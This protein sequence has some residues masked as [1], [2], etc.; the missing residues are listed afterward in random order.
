MSKKEV[1]VCLSKS[2]NV[3]SDILN[4]LTKELAFSFSTFIDLK[5]VCFILLTHYE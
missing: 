3:E 5:S 1:R 4:H 2:I